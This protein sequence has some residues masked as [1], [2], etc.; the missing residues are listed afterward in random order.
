MS[1]VNKKT[2]PPTPYDDARWHLHRAKCKLE[3]F[4]IGIWGRVRDA[5]HHLE[6]ARLAVAAIEEME[7]GEGDVHRVQR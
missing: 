3:G 2:P 5:R 6:Q 4:W 1:I 7:G